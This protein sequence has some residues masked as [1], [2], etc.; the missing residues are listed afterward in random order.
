MNPAIPRS[1]LLTGFA[2][3]LAALLVAEVPWQTL[4]PAWREPLA[5]GLATAVLAAAFG[6]WSSPWGGYLAGLLVPVGILGLWAAGAPALAATALLLLAGLAVGSLLGDAR[7]ADLAIPTWIAGLGLIAGIAGWLLP[8]PVHAH[9]LWACVLSALVIWRR[10]AIVEQVSAL[11]QDERRSVAA[12][13]ALALT[14]CVVVAVSLLPAWL[15]VRNADDLSLRIGIANELIQLGHARLDIGTQAWALA[16]WSTDVLHAI[17]SVIAGKV[18]TSF[19]SAFWLIAAGAAV[20]RLAVAYGASPGAAWWAAMLFASLPMTSALS[21][22]LQVEGATP[23]IFAAL[24]LAITSPTGS[25]GRKLVLVAVIA[26]FAMGAKA[27]NA[28]A[29]APLGA[30]WIA[31]CWRQTP[32]LPVVPATALGLMCGGSSYFYA[33]WLA[34]NP[35][36]PVMNGIFQSPWFP[37]RNFVDA[38]WQTGVPWDVAWK[39]VADSSLYFEGRDGAAGVVVLALAGGCLLALARPG[40]GLAMAAIAAFILIL[41]QVQYLRYFHPLLALLIPVSVA[42]LSPRDGDETWRGAIYGAMVAIQIALIPTSS[43]MFLNGAFSLMVTGGATAVLERFVPE[44]IV[45]ER[46]LSR[47]APTDRVVFSHYGQAADMPL[48]GL[49]TD[50]HAPLINE[51]RGGIDHPAERWAAVIARSGANHVLARD[52]ESTPGLL[53]FLSTAGATRID[54]EGTAHLFRLSP[55]LEHV[56]ATMHGE[57]IRASAPI[58]GDSSRIML[59]EAQ[60]SARCDRPGEP[61]AIGWTIS[62]GGAQLAGRWAWVMCPPSG[63][64]STTAY[65]SRVPSGSM[66]HVSASRARP[67]D[68]LQLSEARMGIDIRED[69]KSQGEQYRR[70]W[71]AICRGL[72]GQDAPELDLGP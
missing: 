26:G 42:A 15:P 32:L 58:A 27:S 70:A 45:T 18:T 63:L 17:A 72:C 33:G 47:A 12:N 34:G 29:L 48:F 46:F 30:W 20:R 3:A 22:S 35:V 44:R 6:R 57:E 4:L 13:P 24:A 23:A 64:A 65:F 8:F 36:L 43:W 61:I 62:Q 49:T 39:M 25:R 7:D 21:G 19:L 54:G 9:G 51:A 55:E 16:P 53:E 68:T 11:V 28:L 40:R 69:F 41:W 1:A 66:V 5:V 14:F 10:R 56:Q 52:P 2:A 31:R 50:W 67:D 37:A 59:G 60:L 71:R 38:T